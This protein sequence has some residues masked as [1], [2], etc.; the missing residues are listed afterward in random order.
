[1]AYPGPDDTTPNDTPAESPGGDDAA[2]AAPAP[3]T[4][5]TH[6]VTLDKTNED[7][8]SAFE[9]CKVGDMYKVTEDTD[10]TITL[11][12]TGGAEAETPAEDAGEPGEETNGPVA[13]L[14]AKKM[15]R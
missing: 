11:E 15:K 9:G 12:K 4:A 8:A 7:I 3:A 6:T 2:A 14:M 10:T 13:L 5:D 1:M